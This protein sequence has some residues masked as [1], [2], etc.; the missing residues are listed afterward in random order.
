MILAN[1]AVSV[2]GV[3]R[4]LRDRGLRVP[5]DVAVAAFDDFAWADLMNPGLTTIA[6]PIPQMGN[7][8]A[9]LLIKRIAGYDRPPQQQVLRPA[10]QHRE[11]C[12]CP[13]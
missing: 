12:G 6:Q 3:L 9:K 4:G 7:V 5:D 2:V 8:P 1:N 10:F 13:P 11:S